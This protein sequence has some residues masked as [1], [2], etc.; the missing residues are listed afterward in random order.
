M[1]AIYLTGF[2]GAGKTTVGRRLGEVL[3][4]PVID[5]DTYI[6][7]Q[8][9]KTIAQ[10]FSG[11][12]EGTFRAYEREILRQLPTE[13]VIVTTGGGIVIQEEN[14]QFM[15]AHGIVIYLH[16]ELH[17]LF[18]RLADDATRP[19]IMKNKQEQIKKLF[20]QR[21]PW[22]KEAHMTIDTTNRTVDDIV[23][24]IVFMLKTPHF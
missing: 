18:R 11:E 24:S 16:C 7:Q 4:V 10:I 14:R 3:G 12:G 22:Y 9:G 21:L 15:R 1:R 19:L 2:M 13:H 6:E 20:E 23:Q 5:T 17:E 8:T